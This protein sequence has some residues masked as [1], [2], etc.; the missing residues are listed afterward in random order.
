MLR[1]NNG[2]Q[3]LHGK[4]Y[5][6]QIFIII[7]GIFILSLYANIA[8]SQDTSVNTQ[9]NN[10]A[11]LNFDSQ[12]VKA[13]I[14]EVP[15]FEEIVGYLRPTAVTVLSSK[16]LGNVVEVLK[17]E[18]DIVQAGELLVKIDSKEIGSDLLGAQAAISEAEAALAE[19]KNQIKSAQSAKEAAESNLKLAETSYNRIK[20]L[21]EKKSVTKQEFDE[22]TNRLNQ[23]RSNFEQANSQIFALQARLS[24]ISAR[25]E[26]AKANAAKVSTIKSLTEVKA[27]F[28]AKVVARKV[29]PGA[30]AA[31]G[32]PLMV[33]EDLGQIRF[34]ASV[35]ERLIGLL[36]EGTKI[37]VQI[38]ALNKEKFEGTVVE[39][40]PSADPMSLTFTVKIALP[41]DSRLRSGMF[42]KGFV[43]KG[44][45]KVLLVPQ[46]AIERRGQLE[47]I[48]VKSPTSGNIVYRLVKTGRSF[49]DKVEILSGLAEG[50]FYLPTIPSA[51]TSKF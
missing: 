29:E 31:P 25:L 32:V 5:N 17:R 11:N 51:N 24:Q 18:G 28:A 30:L 45:Q 6:Y 13:S 23:A 7:A 43:N 48:Y 15:E 3:K 27:P 10:T 50:E 41:S 49:D 2:M 40:V 37:T 46:S 9:Q 34:E 39:I 26:Q 12:L 21:Y 22:A 8:Q 4:N 1:I 14:E 44:N 16:V 38:D 20:D 47:G 42:A 33:L 19:V 36:T 35:P